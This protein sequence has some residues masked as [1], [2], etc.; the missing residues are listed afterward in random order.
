MLYLSY[1][2]FVLCLICFM[3][4]L[5]YALFVLYYICLLYLYCDIF[6]RCFIERLYHGTEKKRNF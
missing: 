4:Y 5:S 3:F 2:L 6:A 1:A